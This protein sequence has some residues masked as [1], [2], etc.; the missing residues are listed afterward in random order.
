MSHTTPGTIHSHDLSNTLGAQ[1]A[2]GTHYLSDTSNT[3][4]HHIH[5]VS[6]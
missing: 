2:P 1:R 5:G 6:G 4:V 3:S